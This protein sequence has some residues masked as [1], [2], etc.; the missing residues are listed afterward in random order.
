MEYEFSQF[1]NAIRNSLRQITT[2]CTQANHYC[3]Y[4]I[5]SL[6]HARKHSKRHFHLRISINP[7]PGSSV[8]LLSSRIRRISYCTRSAHKAFNFETHSVCAPDSYFSTSNAHAPYN[9]RKDDSNIPLVAR[10]F[11]KSI[12]TN[13]SRVRRETRTTSSQISDCNR[14]MTLFSLSVYLSSLNPSLSFNLAAVFI[15]TFRAVSR[16]SENKCRARFS[17]ITTA[18]SLLLPCPDFL[19]L[20]VCLQPR[21]FKMK[22]EVGLIIL[23][24]G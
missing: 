8:R 2:R 12:Y 10:H 21:L 16:Q 11:N 20:D 7:T 24:N 9:E 15:I 23:C 13:E 5:K 17:E 3:L 4:R 19:E 22:Y 18:E 14:E 6:F 1:R